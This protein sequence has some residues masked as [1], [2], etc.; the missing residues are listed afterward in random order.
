MCSLVSGQGLNKKKE[1]FIRKVNYGG[2]KLTAN[3]RI[4][5]VFL[6]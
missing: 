1:H 3:T 6:N 2:T 5:I 4:I